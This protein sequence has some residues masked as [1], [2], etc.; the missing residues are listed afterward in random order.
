MR[1]KGLGLARGWQMPGVRAEQNWQ[2]PRSSR[3][4]WGV[5]AGRSCN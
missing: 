1:I 4:R 2:M 5:G 3:G